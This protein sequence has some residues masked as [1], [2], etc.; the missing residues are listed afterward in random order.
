MADVHG[1]AVEVLVVVN[2]PDSGPGR[3]TAWLEELGARLTTVAED[4]V[5]DSPAGYDAVLLLGGGFMPDDDHRAPWLPRERLLARRALRDGVPVLGI[6]LGAQL[7][8][9]VSGGTVVADSGRPERGSV[10]IRR[11]PESAA[12][13]VLG[14]LPGEFP[15]IQHHRD[16][17]VAL[18]P[19]AVHLA[20]SE[21]CPV[22]AFRLGETAWGLQ[23][24]PEVAADRLDRWDASRLAAEGADLDELRATATAAEPASA[25]AARALLDA[26][27]AVVRARAAARPD[28][29]QVSSGPASA[30]GWRR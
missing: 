20:S 22:Q 2:D 9:L 10:V 27:V 29:G 1:P 3:F 26:F 28:E 13:P 11:L 8:A 23:F 21:R 7:L 12:D 6:C 4:E 18:P 15:A 30:P 14:G 17:I 16:E 5:P 19:G 24:H 25:A